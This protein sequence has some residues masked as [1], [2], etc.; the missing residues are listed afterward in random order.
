VIQSLPEANQKLTLSCLSEGWSITGFQFAMF[1]SSVLAFVLN[2]TIFWNTAMNSALTQ[3]V[4]GQVKQ[5]KPIF[6]HL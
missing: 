6:V 2:F 1:G 5:I 4:A 3:T